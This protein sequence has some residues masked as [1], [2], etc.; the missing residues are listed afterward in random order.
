MTIDRRRDMQEKLFVARERRSFEDRARADRIV[1]LWAAEQ[2]GLKGQAIDAYTGSVIGAGVAR[3]GGRGGFDKVA[4]D[5]VALGISADTVRAR[6]AM[7]MDEGVMIG[8]SVAIANANSLY[9]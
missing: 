8:R 3:P 2:L 6:Y 9:A 5:L 7:A 4:A 1:G